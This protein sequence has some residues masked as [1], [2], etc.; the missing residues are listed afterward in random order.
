MVPK[1]KV[2]IALFFQQVSPGKHIG[3][4][5]APLPI[6][7]LAT[8]CLL[9]TACNSKTPTPSP[10]TLV[11]T[12]GQTKLTYE[13]IVYSKAVHKAQN[14]GEEIDDTTG[15]VMLLKKCV[16]RE[17]ARIEK[18]DVSE[19]DIDA[20]SD[21]VDTN[22]RSTEMLKAVKEVFGEDVSAYRRIFL[23]PK[24]VEKK[25]RF[26]FST[27]RRIHRGPA[28]LIERARQD[29]LGGASLQE[30][31]EKN[32]LKFAKWTQKDPG[33]A[34]PSPSP[35]AK[36]PGEDPLFEVLRSMAEGEIH[37][38]VIENDKVFR[39]VHLIRRGEGEYSLEGIL[40]PKQ[41]YDDWHRGIALELRVTI[42]NPELYD[43]IQR[44]YEGAWWLRT[45][46]G[47]GQ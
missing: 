20:M 44:D 16:N 43:S 2:G 26:Y 24:V 27:D 36:K 7:C 4:V 3:S 22:V 15:L 14:H 32:N 13:D 29:V 5:G 47:P 30:A 12:A 34:N 23:Q 37:K 40:V 41:K 25:L 18:L 31:A 6:I 11:A 19:A 38:E 10:D 9:L 35:T 46:V 39:L 17:V 45:V 1:M 42:Y 8:A 33:G 21:Y 28:D